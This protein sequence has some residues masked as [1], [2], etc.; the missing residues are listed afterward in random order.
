MHDFGSF[1]HRVLIAD[2]S[3]G[4][5]R[6]NANA[7]LTHGYGASYGHAH[8]IYPMPNVRSS[9]PRGPTSMVVR[10]SNAHPHS[11]APYPSTRRCCHGHLKL[12]R[13]DTLAS[14]PL[15]YYVLPNLAGAPTTM[16]Q[17]PQPPVTASCPAWMPLTT[18]QAYL[19]VPP[20]TAHAFHSSMV[21]PLMPMG[22]T[23]ISAVPTVLADLGLGEGAENSGSRETRPPPTPG[24]E[25]VLMAQQMR[26]TTGDMSLYGLTSMTYGSVE[27]AESD[28]CDKSLQIPGRVLPPPAALFG[29]QSVP[30]TDGSRRFTTIRNPPRPD[31]ATAMPRPQLPPP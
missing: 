28:T 12:Q 3:V 8:S 11:K 23:T 20:V 22:A 29:I 19:R 18:L 17:V 26:C 24:S 31:V 21:P 30:R 1:P 27:P 9:T 14:L 10:G 15:S 6:S 25:T 2:S 7:D 13:H 5:L 16:Y 4:N